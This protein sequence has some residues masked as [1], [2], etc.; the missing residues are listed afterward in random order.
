MSANS[1]CDPILESQQ[2]LSEFELERFTG[3]GQVFCPMCEEWHKNNSLCQMPMEGCHHE[4][5]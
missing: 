3:K 2:K 4:I 5:I 1:I